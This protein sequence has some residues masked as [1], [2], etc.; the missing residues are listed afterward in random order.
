MP[1]GVPE[2]EVSMVAVGEQ[3]IIGVDSG[4]RRDDSRAGA[5]VLV[6]TVVGTLSVVA[7][8]QRI[9]LPRQIWREQRKYI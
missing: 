2:L 6:G 4:G 7:V 5:M 1:V 3:C 8:P 9:E